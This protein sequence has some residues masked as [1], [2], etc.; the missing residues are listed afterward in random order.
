MSNSANLQIKRMLST[1]LAAMICAIAIA[2]YTIYSYG[3][4]GR[5]I[6]GNII[7]SPHVLERMNVKDLNS[8][9]SH[10]TSFI[11]DSIE[12]SYFD[13]LKSELRQLK[14]DLIT[15]E[16]FYTIVASDKSL[17]DIAKE[18]EEE[19]NQGLLATLMLM[20]RT[21]SVSSLPTTKIFQV[22]QYSEHDYFRVQLQGG[23]GTNEWAYFYKP[24]VYRD[25]MHL[26]TNT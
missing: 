15:Y 21:D 9:T 10:P 13:K 8:K 19:F 4:S 26:F 11:F 2:V 5:Y 14:V 3:P 23:N 7:L 25:I 6:A 22:I 17:K 16:K 12:F 20:M 24:Y 18:I 1:I